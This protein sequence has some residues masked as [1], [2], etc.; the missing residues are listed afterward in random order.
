M[1]AR[2]DALEPKLEAMRLELAETRGRV[3]AAPG[4]FQVLSWLAGIAVALTGVIVA[5]ARLM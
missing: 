1:Q 3:A 2:L 4:A 5:V